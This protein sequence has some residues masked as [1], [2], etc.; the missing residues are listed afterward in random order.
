MVQDAQGQ[1]VLLAVGAAGL[2]PTNMGRVQGDGHRP[3]PHVEAADGAAVLVGDQHPLPELRV[4]L[5]PGHPFDPE[6]QA[7]QLRDAGNELGAELVEKEGGASQVDVWIDRRGLVRRTAMTVPYE[8]VGGPGSTMGLT[9]DFYDFG[10][11]PDIEIPA[12]EA[13]F[14]ATDIG[15][16]ALESALDQ[17]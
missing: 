17:L 1:S 11:S 13:V 9:M 12:D 2:V 3:Q 4:A 10:A 14:D 8:L 16:E 6:R 15:T 5:P 7:E